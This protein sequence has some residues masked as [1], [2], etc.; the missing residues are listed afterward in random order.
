MFVRL[1]NC[2]IMRD[3]KSISTH[4]ENPSSPSKKRRLNDPTSSDNTSNRN[5]STQSNKKPITIK[6]KVP[7][8]INLFKLKDNHP[9]IYDN[10]ADVFKD[11]S[12]DLVSKKLKNEMLSFFLSSQMYNNP[13]FV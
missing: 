13:S 8:I 11:I 2:S 7:Q 6:I 1:I 4:Y 10:E 12:W 9:S 3:R 5:N